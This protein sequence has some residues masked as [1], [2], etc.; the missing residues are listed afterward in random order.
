[1]DYI[2]SGEEQIIEIEVIAPDESNQEFSGSLK[3]VNQV[4]PTD[5]C[6]IDVSLSTP[7]NRDCLIEFRP[8]HWVRYL[9]QS[10]SDIEYRAK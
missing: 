7:R 6:T 2:L 3:I 4:N 10:M 9:I 8:L 5:Y 1:M